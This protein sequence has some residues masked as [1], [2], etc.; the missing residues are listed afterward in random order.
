MF[1]E[2]YLQTSPI[3]KIVKTVLDLLTKPYETNISHLSGNKFRMVFITNLLSKIVNRIME[4]FT[5]SYVCIML[6]WINMLYLVYLNILSILYLVY[7]IF[8]ERWSYWQ[9]VGHFINICTETSFVPYYYFRSLAINFCIYRSTFFELW[10]AI[11][12]VII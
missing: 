8:D 6:P 9:H 4:T 1:T 3:L 12:Y 11:W 5:L 7:H 2:C 10:S